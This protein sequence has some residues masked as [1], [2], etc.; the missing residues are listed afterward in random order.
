MVYSS[1]AFYLPLI[2][3]DAALTNYVCLVVIYHKS[4][5]YNVNLYTGFL[6]V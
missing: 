1:S 2:V 3:A 4:F 6:F 5:T